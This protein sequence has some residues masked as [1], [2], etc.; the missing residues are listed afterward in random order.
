MGERDGT[1]RGLDRQSAD[2]GGAFVT[3][4][5][6]PKAG[7]PLPP[8]EIYE[9]PDQIRFT[10]T[11]PSVD[12][13]GKPAPVREVLPSTPP[14]STLRH[15]PDP[16]AEAGPDRARTRWPL[17]IAGTA[18]LGLGCAG[19][20]AL[21]VGGVWLGTRPAAI[22]EPEPEPVPVVPAEPPPPEEID[23]IPL[24]R[25]LRRGPPVTP[26]STVPDSP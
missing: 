19:V 25:G 21:G 11:P 26:R 20:A 13:S 3:F 16:R 22:A 1:P 6:D 10:P 24:E 4:E 15:Q 14:P 17:V 12:R 7:T 23:G 18:L 2:D 8:E 9:P 5:N